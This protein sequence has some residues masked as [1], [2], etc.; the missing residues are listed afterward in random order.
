MNDQQ[1]SLLLCLAHPDDESF[2]SG[3]MMAMYATQGVNVSL[4]CATRGEV[5]EISDPTLAT[6]DTLSQ[7]REAEL[8]CACETLGVNEPIFLGYRDSGMA[9]TDDNHHSDAFANAPAEAVVPHLVEIIRRLRPQVVVTFDP[10]GG[11]GHPITLP[12]ITTRW[13]RFMRRAMPRS[14][15]SRATPGSQAGC[16][17]P[18][19]P[20]RCLRGCMT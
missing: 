14:T 5:G 11:Y 10:S 9:G 4:V 18:C 12:S 2:G 20:N 8:R 17:T 3:G 16:C 6:P 13:R 1:Q 19:C 7:V 15:R